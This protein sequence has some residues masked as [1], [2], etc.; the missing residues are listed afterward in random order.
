MTSSI[1]AGQ[2]DADDWF[3]LDKYRQLKNKRAT[4]VA[5]IGSIGDMYKVLIGSFSF[6]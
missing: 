3:D 4:D 5:K 1:P 2:T 6:N